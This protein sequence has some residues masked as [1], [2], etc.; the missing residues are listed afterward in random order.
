MT[1]Q[2][3]TIQGWVTEVRSQSRGMLMFIKIWLGGSPN[4]IFQV[5]VS[6]TKDDL[7]ALGIPLNV[8]SKF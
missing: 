5:V 3:I 7:D 1:E 6:G 2:E 8:F 4:N